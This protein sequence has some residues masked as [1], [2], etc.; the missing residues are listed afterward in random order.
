M[1]RTDH[2][3]PYTNNFST[4]V[5][6][7]SGTYGTWDLFKNKLDDFLLNLGTIMMMLY[8][9]M[10]DGFLQKVAVDNL[11]ICHQARFNN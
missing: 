5:E 6:F 8:D 10:L 2:I 1:D 7:V 9:F 3:F 4:S 11:V